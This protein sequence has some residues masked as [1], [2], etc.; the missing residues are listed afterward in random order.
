MFLNNYSTENG[1]AVHFYNGTSDGV[2][3][4]CTFTSNESAKNGGAIGHYYSGYLQVRNSTF[5]GNKAADGAAIY[6]DWNGSYAY[7]YIKIVGSYFYDN[8][9][10]ASGGAIIRENPYPW[11]SLDNQGEDPSITRNA[12][13]SNNT[14]YIF[15]LQDNNKSSFETH[16]LIN[17]YWGFKDSTQIAQNIY[18][19]YEDSNY[20]TDKADFI[21]F[22]FAP[23]DTLVGSPSSINSIKLK[24]NL[25]YQTELNQNNTINTEDTIFVEVQGT[26]S[27]KYSRGLS[28]ILAI[29]RVNQ[30]KNLLKNVKIFYKTKKELDRLCSKDQIS[31]QGLVAE[32]E[33]QDTFS[34]KDFL[35]ENSERNNINFVVLEEVTDPRNIGSIIRSATSFNIDGLIVKERSFPSESKLLFKSA[36]GSMEHIN[37]FEVSNLST[38]LKYLKSK[39]FW[40]C[41][42][43]INAGED[44]TNHNWDGNNVLLFGSEG[45]GL[46]HQTVKNSDFLLKIEMNKKIESLNISNSAAVVCHYIDKIRR[47]K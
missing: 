34:I 16:E 35:I 28:V 29:N 14:D 40:I 24:T 30:D 13:Y 42:F 23:N 44:F 12:F 46:K 21:P 27:D 5:I 41:G 9:S 7:G 11:N 43:D 25:S 38:T 39:N 47:R 10:T 32:I 45:Y 36:S 31:H 26:D 17:N 22:L 19:F 33:H 1:G 37:I 4:N 8:V 15:K 20:E 3:L 2:F 6:N 18:D